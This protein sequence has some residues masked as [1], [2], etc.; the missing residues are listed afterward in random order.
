M[1]HALF[2]LAVITGSCG[3]SEGQSGSSD[4]HINEVVPSNHHS[5]ADENGKSP[6][7]IEMYN[8]SSSDVNLEGYYLSDKTLPVD[9]SHRL[10]DVVVPAGGVLVL[11]ADE[12]PELG[13]KHL[14]FKLN[15]SAESV[16]FYGPDRALLDR[17]DW[18]EAET[19]ISIARFPDGTGPFVSCATPTCKELNGSICAA[20]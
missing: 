9:D 8:G 2:F 13:A 15:S 5:C 3:G 19:D 4:V 11:W 18:S 17:M 14:P 1:K 16:L 12:Q 6:D 20:P 10:G 7:W